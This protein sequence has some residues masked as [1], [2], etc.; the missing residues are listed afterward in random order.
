MQVRADDERRRAARSAEIAARHEGWSAGDPFLGTLHRKMARLHRQAQRQH[1]TAAELHTAHAKR[2][3]AS[4]GIPGQCPPRPVALG[5]R[6]AAD[7]TMPSLRSQK[8]A[9]LITLVESLEIQP[10][11]DGFPSGFIAQ[12]VALLD[13]TAAATL[14]TGPEGRLGI[15][16]W[17]SEAARLF[18]RSELSGGGG[19]SVDCHLAGSHRVYPTN[20]ALATRW[21]HLADMARAAQL[22]AVYVVPLR[23]RDVVF[24]VLTLFDRRPGR[25]GNEALQLVSLLAAA[26]AVALANQR[27]IDDYLRNT[28]QLQFALTSRIAIEQA[29]GA[30]AER[31]GIPVDAAFDLLRSHARANNRNLH[32][33]AA[34]IIDRTLDI[35]PPSSGETAPRPRMPA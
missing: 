29:K 16:G 32:E 31:L 23:R 21:P 1:L 11:G 8:H 27:S 14:V 18:V 2:V 20:T 5:D 34:G 35:L 13:V 28:A 24:G 30:L 9:L 6:A 33:V 17:S 25:A 19:P 10:D 26:A 12:C 22:A 4:P 3:R 15:G 7:T